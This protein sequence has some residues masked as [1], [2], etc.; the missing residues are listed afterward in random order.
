MEKPDPILDT[1]GAKQLPQELKT[2]GLQELSSS[3]VLKIGRPIQVADP[4]FN[5][6]SHKHLNGAS[7][8]INSRL[9]VVNKPTGGF[10]IVRKDVNG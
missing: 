6:E 2:V 7:A 5:D 3:P 9:G 10:S 1:P 4:P 8:V